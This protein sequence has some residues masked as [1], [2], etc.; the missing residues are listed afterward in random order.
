MSRS[1]CLTFISMKADVLRH[2]AAAIE[3]FANE[4]PDIPPFETQAEDD[5][6]RAA[7]KLES[8]LKVVRAALANI[9]TARNLSQA[10]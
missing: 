3:H 7:A 10:G 6:K 2:S 9:E 5:L 1:V 8:A 4:L